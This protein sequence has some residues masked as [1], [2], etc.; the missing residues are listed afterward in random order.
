MST[1]T[2]TL[3]VFSE[4]E[5]S[6]IRDMV[7][8]HKSRRLNQQLV[9]DDELQNTPSEM[10]I[11]RPIDLEDGIPGL[12]PAGAFTGVDGE[13]L[14]VVDDPGV[15]LCEIYQITEGRPGRNEKQV[16]GMTG[17]VTGGTFYL[18]FNGEE[19]TPIA[20]DADASTIQTAID[21]LPGVTSGDIV[22]SGGPLPASDIYIEFVNGLGETDVRQVTV[23]TTNLTGTN[24]GKKELTIQDGGVTFYGG[25]QNT[26]L[27][28][29]VYNVSQ[30]P[31]IDEYIE[32]SRDK[33]G[34][35]FAK[36][37][38]DEFEGVLLDWLDPAT[39]PMSG[40]TLGLMLVVQR[41]YP[42]TSPASSFT[43][44]KY[45]R[46]FHN[47]ALSMKGSPG[48]YGRCGRMNGETRLKYLDCAPS[49]EG[50]QIV[51]EYEEA[52]VNGGYGSGSYGD[53]TI[54]G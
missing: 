20:Y 53:G 33:Y 12:I 45:I 17:N 31:I 24:V 26:G 54:G 46:R 2:L 38:A 5:L 9:V 40:S 29:E 49:E 6:I 42:T 30:S 14:P 23:H 3:P 35:W 19:T 13:E 22:I 52:L 36:S 27:I 1:E 28:E 25:L 21:A 8:V 43:K 48:T 34:D 44:S 10:Y 50:V 11:A 47:R 37:F 32:I 15:A 4:S 7:K 16:V 41:D 51:I 39:G 18:S